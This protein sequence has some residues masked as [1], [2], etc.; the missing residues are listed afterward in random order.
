MMFFLNHDLCNS[1][2][3]SIGHHKTVTYFVESYDH[4]DQEYQVK[5]S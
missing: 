3:E 2:V 1:A 5:W 4:G